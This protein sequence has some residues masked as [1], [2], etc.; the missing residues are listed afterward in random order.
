MESPLSF[1]F[2]I[3]LI[4]LFPILFP[5]SYLCCDIKLYHGANINKVSIIET[6]IET[7]FRSK[8]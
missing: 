4:G 8:N 1:L 6:K 3:L 7:K 2:S 5:F